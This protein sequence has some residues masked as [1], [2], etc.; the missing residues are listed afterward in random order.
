MI[1]SRDTPSKMDT[2]PLLSLNGCALPVEKFFSW[3]EDGNG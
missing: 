3:D 2:S 1:L